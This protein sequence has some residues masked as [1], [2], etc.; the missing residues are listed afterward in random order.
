MNFRFLFHLCASIFLTQEMTSQN[1]EPQNG[2][3]NPRNHYTAFTNATIY[4]GHGNWLTR[5][6]LLIKSQRIEALGKEVQIPKQAIIKDLQGQFIYPSFI[7]LY[8]DFG[9]EKFESKNESKKPQLEG[10]NDGPYFWNESIK[11]E[12][13]ALQFYSYNE[14]QA[15]EYR[16]LGFGAVLSHQEDGVIR[17]T[18]ALISLIEEEERQLLLSNAAMQYSFYKGMSKQTYPSS[19]MG[20]IALIRQVHYDA[21]AYQQLENKSKLNLTLEKLN[22]YAELPKVIEVD[23]YLSALRANRIGDEFNFKFIIKGKGDEY[24]RLNEI[25]ATESSFIIPVNFPKV[26]DVSDPYD[27]MRLP[28]RKMKEWELADENLARLERMQIPFAITVADL[29]EKKDFYKNLKRSLAKG[30]SHDMAIDALS[31][32]PAELIHAEKQIGSLAEG[33]LAN[34]LIVSDTMFK[35]HSKLISNWVQGKEYP[36]LDDQLIDIRGLYSLNINKKIQFDVKIEG[37]LEDLKAFVSEKGKD[38]FEKAA[39]KIERNRINLWFEL[40]DESYRLSGIISDSLSRIWTGK[41]ILEGDWVDWATIKKGNFEEKG[42]STESNQFELSKIQYPLMAFGKDSLP[43]VGETIIFRNAT[44]WTNEVEGIQTKYDVLIHEGKIKMLG[45]KINLAVMFPELINQVK[46]ID[47]TDLHLTSGIIDEHSHIAISRGVN[48]SGQAVTAEVRIGDVINSDDINIYR[49]LAGGVTT[50]QLLH[51]SANPIG[52]QSA[53]IKLRWG[54]S[55]EEMKIKNAPKF[56]KFALGENVK[57]SNWGDHQTLRFPQSRMGVEQVFYDAFTRAKEYQSEWTLYHAKSKKEKKKAFPPRRDLELEALAEILDTNRF[58]TCHSYIQSEINML[59][60]VADS[61]KFRINTFTHVLEGYKLADQ[62]KEHGAAASTFSDWWAYKFEV[63]DAIPYNGAML[64]K[65][66][67]LTAFNSDDAEM[68]RRLNQE[69]AKA[70]KYGGLSAEEAWKLVTLNPAKMLHL[71]SAL[72]SIAVGK[73]ADLV[74]WTANPLSNYSKV[75]Q[76]YIDGI[77]YYDSEEDERQRK[78]LREE[79]ER[80]ISL[81]I[82]AKEKEKKAQKVN[83]E[84]KLLYECETLEQ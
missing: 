28:Y 10:L 40:D 30:L 20:I 42:D 54:Q 1:W 61:M 5:G 7:D 77:L 58:I 48:E 11:A 25:K 21:I 2:A 62:L 80:L 70:M 6:T 15:K 12:Q 55:A 72:G 84:K 78:V 29:E 4:L 81:M 76:T 37:K 32:I 63:N 53:L 43:K 57:Q 52:G 67:V 38:E 33:K 41:T 83:E 13:N 49:Q 65:Q 75:K 51:G 16:E 14:K 31:I 71:D 22:E 26:Y 3:N 36:L 64:H 59:M 56:I 69:A 68:G 8:S 50:S 45:Y 73:D 74:L 66:G 23:G 82:K 46:E 19:L 47:A 9:M 18:S 34:F 24:K 44:V 27:A 35:A 39:V 17:G 79:R 60:H